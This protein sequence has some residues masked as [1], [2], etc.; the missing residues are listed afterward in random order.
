MNIS[1]GDFSLA[2][3]KI[4]LGKLL[5]NS[6]GVQRN[7]GWHKIRKSVVYRTV[8]TQVGTIDLS[9]CVCSWQKE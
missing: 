8:K 9:F 7:R 5:D 4:H 2:L 3:T 6:S 1:T